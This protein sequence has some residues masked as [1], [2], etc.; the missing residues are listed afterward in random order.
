MLRGLIGPTLVLGMLLPN[1]AA[2]QIQPAAPFQPAEQVSPG[3]A[4]RIKGCLVSLLRDVEVPAKRAGVLSSLLVQEGSLV[5]QGDLL[6]AIDKAQVERQLEA[7]RAELE[8]AQA[9]SASVLDIDAAEAAFRSAQVEYSASIEASRLS[10][11]SYSV[12]QLDKLQLAVR[13][14]QLKIGTAKL[15]QSIEVIQE[16]SAASG[17][18]LAE[19]E[20]ADRTVVAPM[21]GVVVEVFR[22]QDEWVEVGR[23]ILRVV[24]LDR[25]R[26]EGFVKYTAYAPDQILG[27][28]VRATAV[29][30]GGTTQVFPGTITFVN[31]I[32]QH[33][34]Q[35][36]IWAEVENPGLVLRPGVEVELDVLAPEAQ[37]TQGAAAL[38]R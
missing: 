34:G 25:L 27:R 32:L 33:G 19:Q 2:A 1:W 22:Q 30:A 14:A 4:F 10:P 3:V 16:K 17:V 31:P 15:E 38:P 20:L 8:T 9:R 23:P 29:V 21:R 35:Y 24:Q 36:R 5:S 7:A 37:P 12:V 6:G 28:K 11:G 18:R 26:V 13:E